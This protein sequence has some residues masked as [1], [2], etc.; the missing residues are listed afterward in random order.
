[1]QD[2]EGVVGACGAE[3]GRLH[4]HFLC[5]RHP[6]YALKPSLYTALE[7]IGVLV[8]PLFCSLVLPLNIKC[9]CLKSW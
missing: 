6:F 9:D 4:P 8:C 2:Q 7:P 3:V 5:T 1:M